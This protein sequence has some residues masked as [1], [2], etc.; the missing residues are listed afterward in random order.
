MHVH[1]KIRE[2]K[3]AT[4]QFEPILLLL[5]VWTFRFPTIDG[6][7]ASSFFIFLQL[8]IIKKIVRYEHHKT[9]QHKILYWH[10]NIKIINNNFVRQYYKKPCINKVIHITTNEKTQIT[11]FDTN[12][13]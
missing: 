6:A 10:R 8:I 9:N 12:L 3:F 13:R 11:I 7:L 5:E 1:A 4:I 2:R